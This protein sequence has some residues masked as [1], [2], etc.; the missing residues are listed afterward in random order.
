MEIS[1]ELRRIR[2]SLTKIENQFGHV[3]EKGEN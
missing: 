3:D 1:R 2:R